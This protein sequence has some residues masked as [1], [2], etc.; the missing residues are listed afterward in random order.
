MK[1][2]LSPATPTEEDDTAW[3]HY[4][5][6]RRLRS[7]VYDVLPLYV[8]AKEADRRDSDLMFQLV[9]WRHP[10]TAQCVKRMSEWYER[11]A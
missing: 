8:R 2:L 4:M 7:I 11:Y 6:R 5:R 9:H 3:N 1:P 10:Q